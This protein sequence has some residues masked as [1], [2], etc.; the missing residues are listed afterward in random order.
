MEE[1]Y[2][3]YGVKTH[4]EL[5][6]NVKSNGIFAARV[7]EDLLEEKF[8]TQ[9]SGSE[10]YGYGDWT[11]DPGEGLIAPGT[12]AVESPEPVAAEHAEVKAE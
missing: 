8:P 9:G 12:T 3:K 2:L 7:V 5:M 11:Q 6:E 1:F 4:N 10:K